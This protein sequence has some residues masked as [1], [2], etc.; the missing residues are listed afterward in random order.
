MFLAIA[1]YHEKLLILT[2]DSNTNNEVIVVCEPSSP[3]NQLQGIKLE[4]KPVSMSGHPLISKSYEMVACAESGHLFISGGL[5]PYDGATYVK[6]VYI[7]KELSPLT[8]ELI[9]L[10]VPRLNIMNID[11]PKLSI[12]SKRLLVIFYNQPMFICDAEGKL[13]QQVSLPENIQL[14]HAVESGRR[15]YIVLYNTV[16]MPDSQMIG[17]F[18][19]SGTLLN[20]YIAVETHQPFCMGCLA[21][22][23]RNSLFV[24]IRRQDNNILVLDSKFKLARIETFAINPQWLFY[25]DATGFL[26]VVTQRSDKHDW[27]PLRLTQ[28]PNT[29]FNEIIEIYDVH[30]SDVSHVTHRVKYAWP[31]GRQRQLLDGCIYTDVEPQF[32]E[33]VLAESGSTEPPK[34]RIR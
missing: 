16:L 27:R 28:E 4:L 26:I 9:S 21:M 25:D 24:A 32:N 23:F 19:G 13:I 6:R 22:G 18:D 1:V 7:G 12:Y 2:R 5:T 8:P 17:E 34:K 20:C 30:S 31:A 3:S 15:T 29:C 11:Q 33:V 14:K 10:P